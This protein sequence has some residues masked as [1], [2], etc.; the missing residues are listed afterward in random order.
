M[1]HYREYQA[2][3]VGSS[4]CTYSSLNKSYGLHSAPSA[5]VSSMAN[6]TVPQYLPNGAGPNYPPKYNTLSHGQEYVCGGYFNM[7]GAYPYA[8]CESCNVN[9]VQRPCNGNLN[10]GS[11][12][13]PVAESFRRRRF[14]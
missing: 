13:A 9:Y 4:G 1:A 11:A 2:P 5:Q 7:Q 8:S 3:T 12:S 10:G 14:R 6:Y